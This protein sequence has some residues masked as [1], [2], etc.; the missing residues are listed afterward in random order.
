M[1]KGL[2]ITGC[3]TALI[4][5][6]SGIYASFTA[7]RKGPILLNSYIW[8]PKKKSPTINRDTE[9]RQATIIYGCISAIFTLSTIN[10]FTGWQWASIL[11]YIFIA[12]VM[13]Y[14]IISYIKDMSK[15]KN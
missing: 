6:I 7:R 12:F 14:A 13:W 15:N 8:M 4:A 9:Y 1:H 3:V 10:I 5:I 11:M 2:I